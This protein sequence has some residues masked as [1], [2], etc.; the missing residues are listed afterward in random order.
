MKPY[1]L[2]LLP[3]TV[4][5]SAASQ[6]FTWRC[7]NPRTICQNRS[8]SGPNPR[9]SCRSIHSRNEPSPARERNQVRARQSPEDKTRAMM[10]LR[11]SSQVRESKSSSQK[12]GCRNSGR[13]VLDV[14][15]DFLVFMDRSLREQPAY[16][17]SYNQYIRNLR[18][19][20]ISEKHELGRS[21]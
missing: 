13:F 7:G 6:M 14:F 20:S 2:T 10:N 16:L 19:M 11:S 8:L 5:L 3:Q 21:V 4:F 15:C 18:G 12:K 17:N 9:P 1:G